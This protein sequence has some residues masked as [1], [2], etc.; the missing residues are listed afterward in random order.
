V[1][2]LARKII[3][4]IWDRENRNAINDNF[5]E[6]YESKDAID[7]IKEVADY[8]VSTAESAKEKAES[9]QAQLNQAV[10]EGDSSVEAAQARVD[11]EGNSYPTLKAR[12][13]A[14]ETEFSSRLAQT[15]Q[16]IIELQENKANKTDV[17]SRLEQ[18]DLKIADINQ[19]IEAVKEKDLQEPFYVCHRGAMNIFPENSLE[20]F[21]GCVNLGIPVIEMD[22]RTLLDGSLGIMHDSTVDRT[23]DKTGNVKDFSAMGF[24]NLKINNLNG[25]KE[26]YAPLLED[27]FLALGNKAVYFIETKDNV[28]MPKVVDLVKKHRLEEYV[29]AMSFDIDDLNSAISENIPT[30]FLTK[31]AN[32][33]VSPEEIKNRGIEYVGVSTS[34]SETYVQNLIQQDIKVLVYT[35]NQRYI[36]DKFLSLG[37]TGIISDDPFYA[38]EKI[39]PLNNDPYKNGVFYHGMVGSKGYRGGFEGG[40]WG[41]TELTTDLGSDNTRRDFVL[42]GWAGVL[43]NEFELTFDLKRGQGEYWS[44]V[45]FSQTDE[46]D[47]PASE[48]VNGYMIMFVA[49]GRVY[50]HKFQN[51]T[52]TSIGSVTDGSPFQIGETVSVKI[53][54]TSNQISVEV[55]QKNLSLTVEDS[56]YRN[57]YLHFGRREAQWFF[58]NVKIQ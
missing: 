58:S 35:V 46:F 12:L 26:V 23:T 50:I 4:S 11:A 56:E 21:Q 16:D 17:N 14:K 9:V 28:S 18:T 57:G 48:R 25:Y 20:A 2:C 43:P 22:V 40:S 39:E 13:D 7:S 47:D 32:P 27:V 31:G 10:I 55:P 36:R 44:A 3:G 37:V 24:K 42:Q 1:I 38:S 19:K 34:V 45:A 29:V 49:A 33:N 6:L 54:V 8:A 41:F 15:E 30:C 53:T 5:E 52:P 51:G